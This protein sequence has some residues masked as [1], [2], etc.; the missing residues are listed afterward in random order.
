[1]GRRRRR[2][3]DLR[4][5]RDSASRATASAPRALRQALPPAATGALGARALGCKHGVNS[6]N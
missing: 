3:G 6:V 4:A 1:M 5:L 2:R